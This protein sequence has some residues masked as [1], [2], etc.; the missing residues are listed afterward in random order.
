MSAIQQIKCPSSIWSKIQPFFKEY[1][2]KM[3]YHHFTLKLYKTLNRYLYLG[4]SWKHLPTGSGMF[5]IEWFGNWVLSSNFKN[6]H[7]ALK[8]AADLLNYAGLQYKQRSRE[9]NQIL[10]KDTVLPPG[11]HFVDK[12]IQ[13]RELT[14]FKRCSHRPA[15]KHRDE[16]REGKLLSDSKYCNQQLWHEEKL[17][18]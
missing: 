14:V 7:S 9:F 15:E 10:S 18:H 3:K 2:S 4:F 11:R 6:T 12:T 17:N 5:F 16:E 8:A 13:K 1:V